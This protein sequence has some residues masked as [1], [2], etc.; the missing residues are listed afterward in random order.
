VKFSDAI[1]KG[2]YGVYTAGPTWEKDCYYAAFRGLHGRDPTISEAFEFYHT[3]PW[4]FPSDTE[5]VVRLMT[6]HN[7]KWSEVIRKLRGLGL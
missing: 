2:A 1:E 7:L 4:G 3:A 5:Y 6:V